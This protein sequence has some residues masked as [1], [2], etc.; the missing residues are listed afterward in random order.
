YSVAAEAAQGG[1]PMLRPL[2]LE[3]PK[4][5][6]LRAVEDAF[7]LGNSLLIAPVLER[8]MA[9][10]DVLLPAGAWYDFF[11][12]QPYA[13]GQLVRLAAPLERMPILVR[14]GHVLPLREAQQYVEQKPPEELLL[15]VYVG[16]GENSLYEDAG[17]G[18][19]YQQI[20]YRWLYFGCQVAPSGNVTLSWRRVGDYCAPYSRYRF[21][22]YGIPDEPSSIYLD[23]S[24][25]PLWYYEKGVVEFTATQP[26]ER[27]RIEVHQRS[28]SRA[29]LL[30]SPLRGRD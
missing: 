24:A 6:P 27:A 22:I 19:A 4:E 16:K 11:T 20:A 9:E 25:A 8:G 23:D 29:T 13:G 17:E 7:L 30:R 15:R 12:A 2:W 21:E 3:A 26:F 1:A 28:D 18:F 10:R 14:A 5:L